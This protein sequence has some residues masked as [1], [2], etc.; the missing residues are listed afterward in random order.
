MHIDL[1]PLTRKHLK[2]MYHLSP[3]LWAVVRGCGDAPSI[4]QR[5]AKPLDGIELGIISA[6]RLGLIR[7]DDDRLVPEHPHAKGLYKVI[8]PELS[9]SLRHPIL[10]ALGEGP[11]T[12]G[13]IAHAVGRP[14]HSVYKTLRRFHDRGHVIRVD[15]RWRQA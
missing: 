3:I 15:K 6:I 4:A 10:D 9:L 7:R 12:T 5:L 1:D 8:N 11:M 2:N 14:Y 13:D